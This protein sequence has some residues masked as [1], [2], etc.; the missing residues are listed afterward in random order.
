LTIGAAAEAMSAIEEAAHAAKQYFGCGPQSDLNPWVLGT[1]KRYKRD[2][3]ENIKA[4]KE[5]IYFPQR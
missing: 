1:G 3:S 2:W 4:R 5:P